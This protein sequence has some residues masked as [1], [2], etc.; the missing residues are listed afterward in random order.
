MSDTIARQSAVTSAPGGLLARIVGVLTSPRATYADVAAR[1]RWAGVLAVV[2]FV[3][4]T[5]TGTFSSTEVGQ[6]A[7]LDQ[8]R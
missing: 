6:R 7:L 1:P 5:A 8:P 3:S 2:V 4:A